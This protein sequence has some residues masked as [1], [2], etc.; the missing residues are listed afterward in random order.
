MDRKVIKPAKRPKPKQRRTETPGI[1]YH[2]FSSDPRPRR[3]GG[4]GRGGG[5]AGGSSCRPQSGA[6]TAST[7]GVDAGATPDS[8]ADGDD[9]LMPD[10]APYEPA[11]APATAATQASQDAAAAPGAGN[12]VT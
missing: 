3:A 1:T 10:A 12:A 11:G 9:E 8:L 2:T 7:P 5:R 6:T 4:V